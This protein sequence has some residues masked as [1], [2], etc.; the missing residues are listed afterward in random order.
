MKIELVSVGTELLLG[1][2]VNTN[3]AYL[4]KALAKLGFNVFKHTTVGD[5]PQRLFRALNL[6]F[7]ES[8]TV[9]ITGGLGPTDDDISREIAANFLGMPLEYNDDIW[10]KIVS[11]VTNNNPNI[12]LTDNNKK[13]AYVPEGA[14]IL[15]NPIGTA[16]GLIL[17]KE[18]R[19]IILL[20]GPPREM[21]EMFDNKVIPYLN[22]FKNQQ[23]VS[24]YVR[25][26]GIGES[27]LETKIKSMLD[28]QSNPTLA[29]YAKTG[30][31]LIRITAASE[32]E[33]E[34]LTKIDSVINEL[35]AR[36]GEFI[37]HIGG[38]EVSET[39]TE[40]HRL[41][42]RQLLENNF[43]F[44]V[45]ESITGGEI[46][47]LLIEQSG[48][49]KIFMEGIVCYSNES[50]KIALNVKDETLTNFG[51]V[52]A[53]VAEEM[54]RGIAE[55]L[56]VNAAI[57]TTGIAG[58]NS[59]DTEKPVGLVYIGTYLNGQIKIEQYQFY[60]NRELIRYRTAITALNQLRIMIIEN[61]S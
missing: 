43:T 37:Y 28:E 49:S 14:I 25:F 29:L 1:D 60:G 58:P 51:A 2:I 26:F 36:V 55:R 48:I 57:A 41:V 5:N 61:Q 52:S 12:N 35:K 19:R 18:Q 8:D 11:Y 33:I 45:A 16:P 9:I 24:R 47:S 42:A 22:Q 21:T 17:E 7:E 13:Q 38:E 31:V 30:E 40:M 10:R 6:A 34:G 46:A 44:S 59:D 20:P 4:S 23:I 39:Q 53:E 3:T 15:E 32:N 56:S 54:V 27:A 50:K